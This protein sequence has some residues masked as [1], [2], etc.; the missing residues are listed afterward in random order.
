LRDV[1][2]A[3][4]GLLVH[5]QGADAGG[6][7]VQARR[8]IVLSLLLTSSS[9]SVPAVVLAAP[10]GEAEPDLHG[11]HQDDGRHDEAEDVHVFFLPLFA[12]PF[13]AARSK[14][15]CVRGSVR[16]TFMAA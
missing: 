3:G 6:I 8:L 9:S 1:Q 14:T 7:D 5:G 16:R 10:E 2:R 12:L 15:R 13:G 11:G 4:D